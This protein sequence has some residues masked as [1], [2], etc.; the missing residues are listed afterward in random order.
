MSLTDPTIKLTPEQAKK[1]S[2]TRVA[3]LWYCPAFAHIFYSM[4]NTQGSEYIAKF[5]T[6]PAVPTAATDGSC[7]ILNPE[8]FFEYDL[9]ERLFI[10]AHEIMHCILNH[11]VIADTFRRRGAVSYPDGKD[12]PY[13]HELMNIALD[14]V[15]NDILVESKVGKYNPK[16][17]H[18]PA[19]GNQTE[20]GTDVYRKIYKQG[21]GGGGGNCRNGQGG[22]DTHLQPGTTAGQDPQTAAANRNNA[23]WQT[24]VAQAKH[25]AKVQGKLPAGLERLLDEVMDP[26]VD[27][28]EHI[29]AVFAR[30]VGSSMNDFRTLDRRLI[31]RDIIAPGRSGHAADTVVVAA[32]TSGS[33]GETELNAFFAEVSGILE[34]L[35]PRQLFLV[36]CDA[37][38]QRVDECDD[39]GDL[40]TLRFKGAPGGGGTSFI[41]VF[42][43]MAENQIE[44]DALVYLTD[45]RGSFP[46]NHPSYPVIWGSI[47]DDV[48]YPFGEV[49][50]I[51]VYDD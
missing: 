32:D 40:N 31:V 12:I 42:E 49:V 19:T 38:V 46:K 47:S 7:L 10:V 16:W 28:R 17:Y 34:D 20:A 45:G 44:P 43:W 33:I 41:P 9:E 25:A 39:P 15:I 21:K 3:L 26:K 27:W 36:W 48:Q 1:W 2:D 13:D 51:P 18:D 37:V 14:L 4:L 22:F 29:E 11:L 8:S 5:T 35:R 50:H 24:A 23:A 30:K 6:D